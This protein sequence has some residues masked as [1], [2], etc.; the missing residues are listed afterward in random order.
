MRQKWG[1]EN[2]LEEGGKK[3]CERRKT[4][5]VA[6][7]VTGELVHQLRGEKGKEREKN[8]KALR[9]LLDRRQG[10]RKRIYKGVTRWIHG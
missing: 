10:T 1:P 4:G 6:K 2:A 8:G 3:G 7:K 5:T 9:R